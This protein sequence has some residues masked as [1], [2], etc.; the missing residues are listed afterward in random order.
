[1]TPRRIRVKVGDHWYTVEVGDLSSSPVEV[2]VDGE[3]FLV[4]VERP[5]PKPPAPANPTT[6]APPPPVRPV[7]PAVTRPSEKLLRAPMPAKV[8]SVAV[9][10][11][12]QV[13]PGDTLCVLDAMK[14]EQAMRAPQAGTVKAVPIQAGQ[15]V[16]HGDTLVE[17]E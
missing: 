11:G 6:K 2:T 10:P 14:M 16:N 4:E 13:S 17:L 7:Q 9:K 5:S 8:V 15:Q 12:D 1:M 3:R